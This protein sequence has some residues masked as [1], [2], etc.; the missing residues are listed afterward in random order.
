MPSMRSS[1]EI[2]QENPSLPELIAQSQNGNLPAFRLLMDSQKQYAYIVAIRLLRDEENAKDVVQEAF[3]RVWNN[4]GRYRK[5]VKFTTWL[6]K[7]VVNLC[8]DKIKMEK[9]QKNIF[10]SVG[11]LFRSDDVADNRDLQNEIE[12]NDLHERVLSESKK[13]PPKEYLV[14]QLRDVQ[15]FSIEEISEIIGMSIGSVK[16]NLC[17]ARQRMRAA[18]N[19]LEESEYV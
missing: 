6:Y 9:R 13:L 7:I 17:Y 2:N 4:L 16:T 10:G 12:I 11:D 14:F 3:I 1:P 8:F 5:E 15:D 19:R 18:I